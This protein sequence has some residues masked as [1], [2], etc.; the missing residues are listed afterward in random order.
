MQDKAVEAPE[1]LVMEGLEPLLSQLD[2]WNFPIFTLTDKTDGRTGRILSQV[3][4]PPSMHPSL[5]PSG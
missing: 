2:N 4:L 1:P 3:S 5:H